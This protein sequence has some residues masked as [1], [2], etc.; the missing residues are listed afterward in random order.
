M[1]SLLV[2]LCGVALNN[3]IP[4]DIAIPMDKLAAEAEGHE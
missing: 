3:E 1:V 2:L 4:A